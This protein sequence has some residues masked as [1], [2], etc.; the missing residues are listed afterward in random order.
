MSRDEN[1]EGLDEVSRAEDVILG[2]LGFGED[3]KIIEFRRDGEVYRG[4]A[5]W[6]DGEQFEFETAVT[7]MSELE[8]WAVDT[9]M[10]AAGSVN[11]QDD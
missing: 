2:S 5:S 1:D 7:E 8:L 11:L 4:I 3:A 10:K 6:S 9:F